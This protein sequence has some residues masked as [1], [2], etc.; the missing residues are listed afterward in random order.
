MLNKGRYKILGARHSL[1]QLCLSLAVLSFCLPLEPLRSARLHNHFSERVVPLTE[2]EI[3][4]VLQRA[5]EDALGGREGTIIALDPQTGRVRAVVNPQTAFERAFPPGSTIKPFTLLAGLRAGVIESEARLLCRHQ[6]R[7]DDFSIRCAHMSP[8]APFAAAAALAHSCNYYFAKL[9]ERLPPERFDA[10]LAAYKLNADADGAAQTLAARWRRGRW[11]VR[12]TL[13]EGEDLLVTPMQLLTA[14]AALV[15]DGRAGALS[16]IERTTLLEGMRGAV[17]EG[18]AASAALASLPL[19]IFGKTG[20]AT[21]VGDFRTHGWFVGFGTDGGDQSGIE[22]APSDV[23]L[24]VLVFLKR[25]VGS[26]SA[27]LSRQVFAEFAHIQSLQK[28]NA[29]PPVE[30]VSQAATSDS[31]E[32]MSL[33]TARRP[34]SLQEVASVSNV[35]V[36]LTRAGVTKTQSLEDYLFGALAAEASTEDEDAALKAQA[37]VSRTFALKNLRRHGREG[38]D[39][40]DLTHCQR[41]LVVTPHN[42]RPNFHRLL[43]RAV[44]ETAGELLIDER[45]HLASAYFSAAC[46]GATANAETL[47]GVPSRQAYERG[48]RDEFCASMPYS[49]WTDQIPAADLLRALRADPRTSGVGA[50]LDRISVLKRDASG[51]AEIIQLDGERRVQ[52]RGWDFKIII[53]R[54]LGWNILRSSRFE[55]ERRGENFVFYGGGFGHGL[56][57]CQHGAHVMAQRGANYRQIIAHYFPGTNINRAPTTAGRRSEQRAA[58]FAHA[59]APP[60]ARLTLASENFRASFPARSDAREKREIAAALHTLEAARADIRRRLAAASL[61]LPSLA[62]VELFVH[63]TTGDFMAA[64]EQPAW[65]A[66]AVRGRRIETQPLTTLRQRRI[67]ET[68]LR[69]EYAHIII[70][71]ISR[72]RSPRWLAE[73]LAVHIAGES[74]MLARFAPSHNLSLEEIERGLARPASA[75]EMRALYAAAYAEVSRLI[76]REGEAHVW[77]RRLKN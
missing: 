6:Y 50:R 48:V 29:T 1:L 65:V 51:R 3:D 41:F 52:L 11:H 25:G 56:G 31:V 24:A 47:W 72:G 20:T 69:H 33:A 19:H 63:P 71:T 77:Q 55:V 59:I 76:Q 60:P 34:V 32:S 49:S 45:G 67:L 42:E 16:A 30:K 23:R 40:C 15:N 37:I 26:E 75:A 8:S 66:A 73:G 62:D 74:A 27:K 12:T 17:E 21:E 46:G 22:V 61:A 10:T 39:F 68:T 53:G 64:T 2:S 14:Y 54:T 43:R 4:A 13:G 7:R 44:R 5:A 28:D 36:R 58:S 38:Y 9:G 35:R 57:L 18:T 70:E